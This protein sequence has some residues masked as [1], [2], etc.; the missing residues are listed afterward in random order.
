MPLNAYRQAYRKR[1]PWV[2]RRVIV[3]KSQTETLPGTTLAWRKNEGTIGHTGLTLHAIMPNSATTSL[4]LAGIDSTSHLALSYG[5]SGG[6]NYLY[7]KA[8]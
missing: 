3:S 2:N 1:P 6:A 5:Q 4:T 8:V 7:V